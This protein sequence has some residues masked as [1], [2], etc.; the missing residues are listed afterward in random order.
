MYI[1][2]ILQKDQLTKEEKEFLSAELFNILDRVE[3]N[4]HIMLLNSL[5]YSS[6]R[7]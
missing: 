4:F 2:K 6:T 5:G 1:E 3:Q 7:H